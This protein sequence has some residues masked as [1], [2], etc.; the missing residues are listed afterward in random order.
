MSSQSL[1][2]KRVAPGSVNPQLGTTVP[3][4]PPNTAPQLTND[5]FLQWGQTPENAYQENN[6]YAAM[7]F[8]QTAAPTAAVPVAPQNLPAT[9]AAAASNQLARRQPINQAAVSRNRAYEAPSVNNVDSDEGPENSQGW[10]ESLEHLYQR[11]HAAKKDAQAKRK[12]I[13][14][15]VQKLSRYVVLL[16]SKAIYTYVVT[17]E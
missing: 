6:P 10:G 16:S 17:D 2:R 7:G 9:S 8:P 13:P 11:A 5:Q 1:S 4:F 12:Q 15:F 14:P 3:N